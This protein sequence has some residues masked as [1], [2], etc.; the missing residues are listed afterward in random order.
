ISLSDQAAGAGGSSLPPR[1]RGGGLARARRVVGQG[2]WGGGVLWV[3]LVGCG[4][5][6]VFWW[7]FWVL[8]SCWGCCAL[9]GCCCGRGC[10]FLFW[11][12]LSGCWWG[13]FGFFS[14]GVSGSVGF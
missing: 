4:V 9:V 5:G 13:G 8:F 10:V 1:R 12:G 2:F 14:G 3:L 7:G 11:V 6:W